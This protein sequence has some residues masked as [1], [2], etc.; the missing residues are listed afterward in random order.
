MSKEEWLERTIQKATADLRELL[1]QAYDAGY[2]AAIAKV[3]QTVRAES[4]TSLGEAESARALQA[5]AQRAR[6]PDRDKAIL[7]ILSLA[8]R[9]LTLS[10]ITQELLQ[11]GDVVLPGS[12]AGVL[13]RLI[14]S[15]QVRRTGMTY[16]RVASPPSVG[17]EA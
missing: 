9:P 5:R 3:I 6:R 2:N 11:R 7:D 4:V 16:E 13:K 10:E 12:V 17:S 14:A 15:G 1:A 8:E